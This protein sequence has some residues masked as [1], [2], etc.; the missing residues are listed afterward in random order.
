[1]VSGSARVRPLQCLPL[2]LAEDAT[3]QGGD[4]A[5]SDLVLDGKD[6][7]ERAI[8]ALGPEMKTSRD[9][10]ELNGNAQLIASFANAA[11]KQRFDTKLLADGS[12]VRA[13]AAKLKGSGAS[14][15]A[16]TVNAR[17][18]V[19]QL[20]GNALAEVVLVASRTHVYERKH[21][22]RGDIPGRRT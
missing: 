6:V 16:K 7:V 3:A 1:F 17:E 14:R 12:N 5:L 9:F 4:H 11:F 21:G 22:D 8:E 20:F 13:D 10:N 18:R 19:D 2:I 15:H